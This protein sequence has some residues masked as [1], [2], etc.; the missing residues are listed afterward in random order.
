MISRVATIS[1]RRL[2]IEL[3]TVLVNTTGRGDTRDVQDVIA[4]VLTSEGIP[5]VV[6]PYSRDSIPEGFD[7]AIEH[8]SS[9]RGEQRY[10]NISWAQVEIKTRPMTFGELERI[11]PPAL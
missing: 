1:Q 5:S 2:G 3:E 10:S 6:R 4:R 8:D 9:L 7:L 11:L